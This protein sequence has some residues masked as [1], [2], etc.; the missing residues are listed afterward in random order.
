MSNIKSELPIWR[1]DNTYSFVASL[2]ILL[3]TLAS[4]FIYLNRL[5]IVETKLDLSTRIENEILIEMKQW[6]I[7][8]EARLGKIESD[9]AVLQSKNSNLR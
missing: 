7:Q 4:F 2:F 9:V 6:R 8:Y 1:W 5:S 3:L